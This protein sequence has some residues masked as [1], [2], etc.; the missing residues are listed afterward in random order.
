VNLVSVRKALLD[1]S[2]DVWLWRNDEQ[3][4]KMSVSEQPIEWSSHETWFS[5]LLQNPK[6]SIFVGTDSE[7][8]KIGMC[9]F[10]LAS[11]TG[12]AVVSINLNPEM[13]GKQLSAVFLAEAMKVF[14]ETA[15]CDLTALI[16]KENKAS[17]RC[18]ERCGFVYAADLGDFSRYNYG[19]AI[20]I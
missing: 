12:C 18:F 4:R 15:S 2:R 1:D 5:Q 17:I 9:R 20:P 10:D 6:F 7:G 16:K 19:T 3:T 8:K 14:F 13:R 11:D